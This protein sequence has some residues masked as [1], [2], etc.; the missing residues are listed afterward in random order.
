MNNLSVE[1]QASL[2]ILSIL[3]QGSFDKVA[4]EERETEKK[5]R[6]EAFRREPKMV[7]K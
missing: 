7:F 2:Q 5:E 6:E 3:A 4:E 1:K